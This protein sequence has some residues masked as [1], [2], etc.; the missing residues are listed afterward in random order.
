MKGTESGIIG[1][2]LWGHLEAMTMILACPI[3]FLI[4]VGIN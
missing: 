1:N 2:I 4:I 3:I